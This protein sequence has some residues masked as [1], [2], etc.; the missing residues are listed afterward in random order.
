M[1]QAGAQVISSAEVSFSASS[2]RTSSF[3]GSYFSK[4]FP[5]V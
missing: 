3:S 1:N 2:E 5:C 4:A